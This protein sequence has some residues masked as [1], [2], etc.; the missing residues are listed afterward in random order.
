MDVFHTGNY[1]R[2]HYNFL[3]KGLIDE[4]DFSVIASTLYNI[5]FRGSPSS[6]SNYLKNRLKEFDVVLSDQASIHIDLNY[7]PNWKNTVL[8]SDS[9]YNP[10][11]EF[12]ELKLPKLLGEYQYLY[13]LVKPE[14]LITDIID[15][16][17]A[18]KFA[19]ERVDFFLPVANLA[20]EIDGSQHQEAVNFHKDKAR[21]ELFAKHGI[22]TFR[23][24]TF[25]LSNSK[26]VN[27]FGERLRSYLSRNKLVPVYKRLL[28]SDA[29]SSNL[30]YSTI[31]RIQAILIEMLG[32][33]MLFLDDDVWHLWFESEIDSE[34]Y[35]LAIQDLFNWVSLIDRKQ[36]CPSVSIDVE[37]AKYVIDISLSKR[38]DD[39]YFENHII[40]C[41]T[42]H[43][44]YFPEV[45]L[46]G[47][48]GNDYFDSNYSKS[49]DVL[50][51]EYLN[52]NGLLKEIFGY[53]QFNGGQ[54]DIIENVLQKADTIGILPTGGGKSLCY[55]LPAILYSGLTLV[56]CPI[57]SLMRDQ[58]QELNQI[59]FHRS[60]CID[61]DTSTQD[62]NK[63]IRRVAAGQIRFLFVSPERL[64]ISNFRE[65]IQSL[66]M[67]KL[68]S[69][70]V[71]DEVHCMSEWGHDFRTSYLTLPYT[72]DN[73]AR[74][75]PRLCLTATASKKVLEDI[76][77]EFKIES[78]NVKTLS[79]YERKN[80]HFSVVE[81]EPFEKVHKV[82][83]ERIERHQI[84]EQN[85]A[86]V[87]TSFVNGNSGAFPLY[88]HIKEYVPNANFF[89]GGK[90]KNHVTKDFE[91]EKSITQKGFKQNKFPL[92]VATKAFG[93]G[94]NKT[95]VYTT[96]HV[97]L[98]QSVESLYQEA[99]RAGRDRTDSDC[100]VLF[101][102]PT[103]SAYDRFFN[104]RDFRSFSKLDL[105][106]D[107]GDLA[108]HHFFLKTS[109]QDNYEAPPVIERI[110]RYLSQKESEKSEIVSSE[111]K[112][113]PSVTQLALYRLYQMG[114]IADWTVEDFSRG[115]YLVDYKIQHISY[116][117]KIVRDLTTSDDSP[118]G[119]GL[120]AEETS[121]T[122]TMED[123]FKAMS[124]LASIV[125][126]HH[127][128]TRVR[129]RIE[130]LKT[131]LLACGEFK[132]AAPD[133]FRENI[134]SYFTIDSINDSL[135]DVVSS[136]G[137]VETIIG[138]LSGAGKSLL[139][140]PS[141]KIQSRLFPL[142]RYIESY[143]G[144]I[145]LGL[146]NEILLFH[147][148][149]VSK[150]RKLL[151]SLNKFKETKVNSGEYYAFLKEMSPLFDEDK[152]KLLELEISSELESLEELDCFAKE[153]NSDA[154]TG[155]LIMKIEPDLTG[156]SRKLYE[157]V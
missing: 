124:R 17:E 42:D 126:D 106:K 100:Y 59:G 103:D 123:W 148:N 96:V 102:P 48:T 51:L 47:T 149:D 69:L 89:T 57:K 130:S 93:M 146:I 88:Q 143:P 6:P 66:Y 119:R 53:D 136:G 21:N 150:P 36:K 97:G 25:Q 111:F 147:L 54:I 87:F 13:S 28:S 15:V 156:I 144:D 95:N 157:L 85:A 74:H 8:G 135:S 12:F 122:Q 82:L 9:D 67:Q 153:F 19:Q 55:Q 94:V 108:I 50:D 107:G 40:F 60:A 45:V 132:G 99:G 32:R 10:A 114:L 91:A 151:D 70:V 75:V 154:V 83:K 7:S 128:D 81:C 64:Q 120:S 65:T 34:L 35:E 145:S 129:S 78:D 23:L 63:I 56:V 44:D 2:S 49:Q 141:H 5:H 41:R 92:L 118:N 98:P 84:D 131:L 142:R 46:P 38:W 79:R 77:N 14:T 4:P 134:E 73:I 140:M 71:I 52:P 152:W 116:Y 139:K 104:Y 22:H 33:H 115:I 76:Q 125:I 39:T 1:V 61:S 43:F 138:Y 109:I 113:T 137:S 155:K 3:I 11:L 112:A 62:K 110:L 24:T 29:S 18:N 86:I 105:R 133:E 20:I 72:L 30:I 121:N 101:K 117:E 37:N 68:L 127:L 58:V 26:E 90:P 16:P 31:F 27:D 80:L